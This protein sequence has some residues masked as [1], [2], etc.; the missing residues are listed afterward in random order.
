MNE[1]QIFIL[2]LIIWI[3]LGG[4]GIWCT[5]FTYRKIYYD[6]TKNDFFKTKEFYLLLQMIG[7]FLPILLLG[8]LLIILSVYMDYP[9]HFTF[10]FKIPKDDNK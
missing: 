1:L 10:Y 6:N 7:I 3:L 2:L 8:G 4:V 9:N 5:L